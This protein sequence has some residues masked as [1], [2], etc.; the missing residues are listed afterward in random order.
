MAVQADYNQVFEGLGIAIQGWRKIGKA[1]RG[2]IGYNDDIMT[3][4]D[5]ANQLTLLELKGL[6]RGVNTDSEGLLYGTIANS[7][8]DWNVQVFASSDRSAGARVASATG[9]GVTPQTITLTEQGD[10]GLIGEVTLAAH[11]ADNNTI[12][13]VPKYNVN[14]LCDDIDPTNA[15]EDLSELLSANN[16]AIQRTSSTVGSSLV[17]ILSSFEARINDYMRGAV[18]KLI[19]SGN[20]R[21]G[22]LLTKTTTTS[23]G[24]VSLTYKGIIKD[25]YDVM[26][27]DSQAFLENTVSFSAFTAGS[28]QQG[29]LTQTTAT[30]MQYV[31]DDDVITL[32]CVKTLD[33]TTEEFEVSSENYGQAFNRL[34]LGANYTAPEI[35][36]SAMKVDRS[37]VFSNYSPAS[38]NTYFAGTFSNVSYSMTG[39]TA[40]FV[41][42]TGDL[43]YGEAEKASADDKVTI[44]YYKGS[45]RATADKIATLTFDNPGNDNPYTATLTQSNASGITIVQPCDDLDSMPDDTTFTWDVQLKISQVEDYY[46]TN[47]SNDEVGI[48]STVLGR[49]YKYELP[50]DGTATISEDYVKVSDDFVVDKKHKS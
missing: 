19:D 34:R 14:A 11:S 9:S 39:E 43:I 28:G 47:A 31:V 44:S 21:S 40:D 16:T 49:I 13:F 48:W 6:V 3:I 37:V 24:E 15:D 4:N 25:L 30:P 5:A 23:A 22:T 38:G 45:S 33:S 42:L 36:I 18:A 1:A 41:N 17:G 46:K 27:A 32:E 7:A 20:R 50:T 29:A 8:G 2:F 35:G 10:S 26:T 12:V